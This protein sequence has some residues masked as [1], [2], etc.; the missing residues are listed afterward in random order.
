M[1]HHRQDNICRIDKDEGPVPE[2]FTMRYDRD[3]FNG[4]DLNT[5]GALIYAS[6]DRN[7]FQTFFTATRVSEKTKQPKSS[8]R[9]FAKDGSKPITVAVGRYKGRTEKFD[10][11]DYLHLRHS[12]LK[13]A[14]ELP[15]DL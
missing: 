15:K 6:K 5:W 3:V 7:C 9:V 2:L 10:P 14:T 8:F 11:M 12:M 4:W 13:G 1:G